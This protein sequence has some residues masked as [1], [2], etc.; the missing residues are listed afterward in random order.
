MF[1]LFLEELKV[2]P[3][4]VVQAQNKNRFWTLEFNVMRLYLIVPHITKGFLPPW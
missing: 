2:F 1:V 4:T 3:L